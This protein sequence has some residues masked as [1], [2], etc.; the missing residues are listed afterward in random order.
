MPDRVWILG[1]LA[2]LLGLLT[3]PIWYNVAANTLSKAPELEMPANEKSCV[4]PKEYMRNNHME[5]LSR[6]RDDV[7]RKNIQLYTAF[8]GKTYRMSLTGTCLGCHASRE[9]F[10][11]RCH[12]YAAVSLYCWDCHIDPKLVRKGVEYAHR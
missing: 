6:W 10:C 3:F 1:G 11:D 7:V 5:L 4:A 8:N 12:N 2:V 9:S